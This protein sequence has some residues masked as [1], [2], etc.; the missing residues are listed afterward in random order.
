MLPYLEITHT[1]SHCHVGLCLIMPNIL[2]KLF[3]LDVPNVMSAQVD[4]KMLTLGTSCRHERVKTNCSIYDAESVTRD[5]QA[6]SGGVDVEP[7]NCS[8]FTRFSVD[9]ALSGT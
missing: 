4:G 1:E 2:W 6:C 5:F 8:L 3:G 9:A 7:K